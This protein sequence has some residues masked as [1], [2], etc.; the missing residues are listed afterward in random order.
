MRRFDWLVVAFTLA[1]VAGS[2]PLALRSGNDE[3]VFYIIVLLVLA[4][5]VGLVH[6]RVALHPACLVG[7]SL[8]GL[9]HMAG[10]LAPSPGGEGV[11]YN[12][13]LVPERLKYDQAV[14][15]YGFGMATWT[16]WQAMRTRLADPRPSFGLM[17][18]AA[19]AGMGLG[20]L[21]EVVEFVAVL[22]IPDTNVGGYE[23]TGWDLVANLTGS[24]VAAAAIWFYGA[25]AEAAAAAPSEPGSR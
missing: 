18:C 1:Y 22:T 4:A 20:A 17:F 25:G 23:N 10:G 5:L 24:F 19:C 13:W 16:V 12:W 11:L 14:H 8:W 7:L 6:L 21:N 3:F 15:A 9:L 2:V